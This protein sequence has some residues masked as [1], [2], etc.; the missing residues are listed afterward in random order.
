MAREPFDSE[1]LI[2]VAMGGVL[3]AL[4]RWLVTAALHGPTEL[5]TI[6]PATWLVNVLGAS[7]LGWII[8]SGVP[9]LRYGF[10]ATGFCGGLTTM[11]TLAVEAAAV[12]RDGRVTSAAAY[13]AFT[14]FTGVGAFWLGSAARRSMRT[15]AKPR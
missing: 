6:R 4:V 9:A 13:L 1:H 14:L 12:I 7:M 3:G 8:A 10:W 15:A 11:S 5:A 2:A